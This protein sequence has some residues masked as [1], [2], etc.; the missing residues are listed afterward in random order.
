MVVGGVRGE[1]GIG[2]GGGGG[3]GSSNNSKI[4]AA[5]AAEAEVEVDFRLR[6]FLTVYTC[7]STSQ[8]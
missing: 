3:G 8:K 4:V 6:P 7:W 2:G 1:V 5:A